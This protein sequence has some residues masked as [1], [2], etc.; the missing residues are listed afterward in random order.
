[1]FRPKFEGPDPDGA[2]FHLVLSKKENYDT[3]RDY[4]II[5]LAHINYGF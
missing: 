1:M 5:L 2:E 3:V 4:F